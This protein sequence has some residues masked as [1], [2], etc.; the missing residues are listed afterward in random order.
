MVDNGKM[1]GSLTPEKFQN[2]YHLKSTQAK[3]KKEYLD[4]FYI[5]NMKDH[6]LKNPWYQEEEG[7]KDRASILKYN[8]TPFIPLV[9]YLMAMLSRLHREANYMF[10]KSEWIPL[11]HGVM[12]YHNNVYFGQH[13]VFQYYSGL[14]KIVQR[15][16][17]RG[18]PFYFLGFI[19]DV[20]CASNLFPCLKWAWT[21]KCPPIHIYY[22]ELWR[23]NYHKEMYSICEHFTAL[24]HRM[25]FRVEMPQILEAGREAISQIG[26][27]YLL[28]EFTYIRITS[29]LVSSNLFPKYVPDQILLKEFVFH[30]F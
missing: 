17:V 1:L 9:Q 11:A 29:I 25:I 14:E 12:F 18:S 24:A 19:L 8:T 10:F 13:F 20:L 30:V 23:E 27:W 26:N 2:I 21:L 4:N 5:V 28:K 6:V 16:D 3:C 22:Q 7:F 15:S